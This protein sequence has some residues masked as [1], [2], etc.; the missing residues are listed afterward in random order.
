MLRAVRLRAEIPALSI[1]RRTSVLIRRDAPLI[2]RVSAERIKAELDRI[3]AADSPSASIRLL[4]RLGLLRHLLPE[5]DP[6]RGLRQNRY[7]HLDAFRHTMEALAAADAPRRLARGLPSLVFMDDPAP[8]AE[9]GR[10]SRAP[11]AL[12]ARAGPPPEVGA[13][14]ARHRQGRHPHRSA[15]TAT[16]TSSCTSRFRPGSRSRSS[17]ACAPRGRRR[18]RSSGSCSSTCGSRFPPPEAS[19]P[20]AMRRIV[21]DAGGSGPAPGAP[22][23]RRQARIARRRPRPDPRRDPPRR[24]ASSSRPGGGRSERSRREP[25]FL[26]GH[27]V[28]RTLG[29]PPGARVGELLEELDELQ[30]AGELRSRAEALSWL[31]GRGAPAR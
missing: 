7:H 4:E 26:D 14:P 9:G 17:G 5:L 8:A 18:P 3:L 30:G 13:P 19:R 29:I 22:L 16:T 6:L 2:R 25:R 23:A 1:E 15:R 24:E 28:M 10:P 21:R 27:D 20:R 31:R 12:P 11:R